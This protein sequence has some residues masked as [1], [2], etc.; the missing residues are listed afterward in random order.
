MTWPKNQASRRIAY[1]NY[2]AKRRAV[3]EATET[4]KRLALTIALKKVSSLERELDVAIARANHFEAR[5]LKEKKLR[6]ATLTEKRRVIY[7]YTGSVTRDEHEKMKKSA[8]AALQKVTVE[9]RKVEERNEFA[10]G[11]SVLEFL[12]KRWIEGDGDKEYKGHES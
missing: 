1:N 12:Q 5:L 9:K 4:A 2:A 7:E 3:K 11:S 8:K 6:F 10:Q